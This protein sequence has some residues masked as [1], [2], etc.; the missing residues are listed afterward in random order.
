VSIFFADEQSVPVPLESLQRLAEVVMSAEGLAADTE[1]SVILVDVD[2][3]SQYNQRFMGR[4]GPTDVLAFPV[5]ELEAGK[6]PVGFAN[7][8]PVTLGDIFVCPQIVA[9]Q[10]V[11]A[12]TN[13]EQEMALI[14]THGLL[15]LLGYDHDSDPEAERMADRERA[16]LAA[17][18]IQLP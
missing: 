14:L 1:L 8:P 18:G 6:P 4:S 11:E 2:E 12:G 13:M 5:E 10:A 17:A 3:I 16:L 9:E 15:H 7:G